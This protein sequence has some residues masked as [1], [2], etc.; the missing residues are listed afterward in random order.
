MSHPPARPKIYHITHGRN[1]AGIMA[2]GCIW[3]YAEIISRGGPE[4][5]IGISEL[6]LHRQ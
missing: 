2:D 1:L 6:G 3:S 5:T 4:A